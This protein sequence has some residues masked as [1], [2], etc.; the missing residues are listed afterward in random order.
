MSIDDLSEELSYYV[1][2]LNDF[3][4]LDIKI[5]NEVII[6]FNKNGMNVTYE[7]ISE[8]TGL[9]I[10]NSIDLRNALASI[11][12]YYNSDRNLFYKNIKLLKNIDEET[13][14]KIVRITQ[15]LNVKGRD[16]LDLLYQIELNSEN[17]F[18]LGLDCQLILS[19]FKEKNKKYY[20]P[21]IRLTM[22]YL[23]TN[24]EEKS[25]IFYV[26]IDKFN[27]FINYLNQIN[28]EISDEL[29][30]Y[31]KK[32]GPSVLMTEVKKE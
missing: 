30:N 4:N 17:P 13:I 8:L 28:N 7:K 6:N 21:Q 25:E 20:L 22:D 5:I 2:F 32:L 24:D 23:D 16:G 9:N 15:K 12:H 31:R 3:L 26:N 14:R 18:L 10:P 19:R 11:I 1:S 27:T 29:M